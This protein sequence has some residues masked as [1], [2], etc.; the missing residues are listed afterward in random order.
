M[1]GNQL[2]VSGV[3]PLAP[4]GFPPPPQAAAKRAVTTTPMILCGA[5]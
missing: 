1:M 3:V 4:L 2:C 5:I